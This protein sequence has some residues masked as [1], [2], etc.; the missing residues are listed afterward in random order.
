MKSF[1]YLKSLYCLSLMI[2]FG[3][4]VSAAP[5]VYSSRDLMLCFRKIGATPGPYELE[6]N[7]GHASTY[8]SAAPGSTINIAQFSTTQITSVFNNLNDVTWSVGGYVQPSD[9][10]DASV[11]AKTLWVTA[12]R[13]SLGSQSVAWVR[14]STFSQ[15]GAGG[16]I[17]S[18]GGNAQTFSGSISADPVYN[19]TTAVRIDS[20]NGKD[21]GSFVGD[22]GDYSSTF[23]GDVEN[24]TPDDFVTGGTSS[25]CDLYELRPST[26]NGPGTY[27]GYFELRTN[28]AVAFVAAG[29]A[30]TPPRPTA[31][32]GTSGSGF[33]ISFS[34]VAGATYNL[35]YTNNVG[36]ISP[37]STW[38]VQ[39][40]IATGNGSTMSV[41]NSS[42]DASR[43]YVI[44]AHY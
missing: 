5:F 35:R 31:V 22:N 44:E 3:F 1:R 2:P 18:I 23:Q 4:S 33:V 26:T 7:I 8:Y 30:S 41:T 6:V 12:P 24:T 25:Y 39:S 28:G 42:S 9:G 43:F 40:N 21:Y 34:T 36:L 15:Q 16:K 14:N 27:L 13:P 20:G 38:P 17:A 19:T 11:P 10:G 37:I 29:G 32:G